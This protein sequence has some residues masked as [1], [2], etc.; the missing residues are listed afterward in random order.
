MKQ[1]T[2]ELKAIIADAPDGATHYAERFR[3]LALNSHK[4]W[5]R[6]DPNGLNGFNWFEADNVSLKSIKYIHSLADIAE[7]IELQ[8]QLA[9]TIKTIRVNCLDGVRESDRR[10]LD[11]ATR[12]EAAL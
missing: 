10:L 3:F 5:M 12:L 11:Y 8:E 1:T 2:Q 9:R 4:K 7:I 6:Y